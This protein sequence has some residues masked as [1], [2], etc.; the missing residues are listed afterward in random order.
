MEKSHKLLEIG[1]VS[2]DDAG[3]PDLWP[4]VSKDISYRDAC[5]IGNERAR[6]IIAYMRSND[7]AHMLLQH[8]HTAM[9]ACIVAYG[10]YQN[11]AVAAFWRTIGVALTD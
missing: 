4:A 6:Q 2:L 10:S 9:V 1:Y 3:R 5:D 8:V 11:D 7:D